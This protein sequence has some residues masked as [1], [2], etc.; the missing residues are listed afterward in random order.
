MSEN[1]KKILQMLSEGKITVDQA[2]KLLEALGNEDSKPAQAA[3]I[4]AKGVP[5][6]LRVIINGTDEDSN[7]KVNV[8]VPMALLR[9]GIKLASILPADATNEIDHNLKEK[10]VNFDFKNLREEDIEPL[11]EAMTEMEV[12]VDSEGSKVKVF[13][14]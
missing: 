1:A 8:R 2:N 3:A 12:D 9:A 14:E 6:Y 7:A 11:I 5:K 10:G 4:T 13:T